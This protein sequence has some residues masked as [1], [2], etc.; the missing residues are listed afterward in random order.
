VLLLLLL[1]LQDLLPLAALP[2]KVTIQE[3]SAHG[4][5][6]LLQ[7]TMLLLL[8]LLLLCLQDLLPLAALPVKAAIQEMSV[9]HAM[10]NNLKT[11]AKMFA[12]V[13]DTNLMQV[14]SGFERGLKPSNY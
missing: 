5:N 12:G 4:S 13:G 2:V 14:G 1:C 9:G 8:L 6:C 3:V 7:Y 10:A 11:K